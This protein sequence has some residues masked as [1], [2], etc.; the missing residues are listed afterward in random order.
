MISGRNQI[1]VFWQI[2]LF[3]AIQNG[4]THGNHRRNLE[5]NEKVGKNGPPYWPVNLFCGNSMTS[6]NAGGDKSNINLRLRKIVVALPLELGQNIFAFL[7]N[8]KHQI[9]SKSEML[10]WWGWW[11]GCHVRSETIYNILSTTTFDWILTQSTC[12]LCTYQ[13]IHRANY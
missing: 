10:M 7:A 6:E 3:H 4:K 5:K 9:S 12:F 2:K 13:N 11:P 1:G 8:P